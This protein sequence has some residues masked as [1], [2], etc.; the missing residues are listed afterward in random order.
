MGHSWDIP[1]NFYNPAEYAECCQMLPH[2]LW[3]QEENGILA[4][5]RTFGILIDAC[6]KRGDLDTA[7]F[8]L[9]R[10][11]LAGQVGEAKCIPVFLQHVRI[12]GTQL[13]EKDALLMLRGKKHD[14]ITFRALLNAAARQGVE[15]W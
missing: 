8:W 14:A 15:Q 13:L 9:Q 2:E 5:K 6:A 3:H 11:E 12:L 4:D 7:D 1:S 10:A